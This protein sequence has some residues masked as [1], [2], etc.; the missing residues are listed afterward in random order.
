MTTGRNARAGRRQRQAAATN[1]RQRAI[2]GVS[3]HLG[4][5]GSENV[6]V[7]RWNGNRM[8]GDGTRAISSG[9]AAW[10]ARWAAGAQAAGRAD[11]KFVCCLYGSREWSGGAAADPGPDRSAYDR[12]GS[13]RGAGACVCDLPQVWAQARASWD[14]SPGAECAAHYWNRASIRFLRN[15]G[16]SRRGVW[17]KLGARVPR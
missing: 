10:D 11:V 14:E 6:G 17:P 2:N 7:V 16:A 15:V 12:F 5:D 4:S 13:H 3:K 9:D 8:H 1:G